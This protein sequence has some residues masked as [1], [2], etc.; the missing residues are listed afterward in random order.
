V[1]EK[2]KTLI[3]PEK[4]SLNFCSKGLRDFRR[5]RDQLAKQPAPRP[6]AKEQLEEIHDH[7]R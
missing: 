1:Q 7:G 3:T 5:L 2:R 6:A 4:R